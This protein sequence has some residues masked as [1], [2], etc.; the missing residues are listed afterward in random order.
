MLL[1]VVTATPVT[2]D[3]GAEATRLDAGG[4]ALVL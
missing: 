2:V 3:E 4:G 1:L